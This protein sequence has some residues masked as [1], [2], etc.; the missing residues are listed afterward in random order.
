MKR[1]KSR[2]RIAKSR[3]SKRDVLHFK[4]DFKNSNLYIRRRQTWVR[5]CEILKISN[6]SNCNNRTV[7]INRT[8][9]K[10]HDTRIRNTTIPNE[11]ESRIVDRDAT[12]GDRDSTTSSSNSC[13]TN[14]SYDS[15]DSTPDES[16]NIHDANFDNFNTENV[17]NINNSA[18][19]TPHKLTKAKILR[20]LSKI[21]KQKFSHIRKPQICKILKL[22]G[23]MLY[24]IVSAIGISNTTLQILNFILENT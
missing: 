5:R 23:G 21:I 14:C 4:L 11:S 6:A 22:F 1:A 20:R 24:V 10:V 12:I 15:L 2:S 16:Y 7:V 3:A 13:I 18:Q 17:T 9:S 19:L 8:L